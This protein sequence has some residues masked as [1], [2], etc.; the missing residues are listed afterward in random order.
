MVRR[1]RVA[2]VR[3]RTQALLVRRVAVGE[4]DLVVTFLTEERGIVAAAAR[5]ARKSAR[6][7]VGLEPMH[8]LAIEVDEREPLE[9]A[10]VVDRILT[11]TAGI[12]Q[13]YLS[14]DE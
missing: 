14:I 5:A 1:A 3:V 8:L 12:M 2:S 13:K 4:A 11:C 6:R 9:N 7:F 10:D